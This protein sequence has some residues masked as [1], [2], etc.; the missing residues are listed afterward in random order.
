MNL[1]ALASIPIG[2]R[3]FNPDLN[4]VLAV[5]TALTAMVLGALAMSLL[6]LFEN[7]RW[8][9]KRTQ[10]EQILLATAIS[11]VFSLLEIANFSG[12]YWSGA[13]PQIMYNV[14][15]GLSNGFGLMST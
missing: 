13:A 5:Y 11:V 7:Q 10:Q 1:C 8:T 12:W 15:S 3:P 14:A 2:L 9:V 4:V 6:V